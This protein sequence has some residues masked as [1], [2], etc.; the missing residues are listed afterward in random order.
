MKVK[1]ESQLAQSC[2]RAFAKLEFQGILHFTSSLIVLER[3]DQIIVHSAHHNKVPT[4]IILSPFS[5]GINITS[6][7][8]TVPTSWTPSWTVLG[9]SKPLS[10]QGDTKSCGAKCYN[11]HRPVSPLCLSQR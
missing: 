10:H 4:M 2:S 7:L 3:T 1:L 5:I 11:F 8:W 6:V 9:F